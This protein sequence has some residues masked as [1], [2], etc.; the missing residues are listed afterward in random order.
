MT[1]TLHDLI[2]S[3]PREI[4]E[5]KKFKLVSLHTLD[6]FYDLKHLFENKIVKVK[7]TEEFPL[8]PS[9]E[10][11]EPIELVDSKG[12]KKTRKTIHLLIRCQLEEIE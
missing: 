3:T 9:L 5:A 2:K 4:L 1:K 10:F 8:C 7:W 12:N 6:S 11:E